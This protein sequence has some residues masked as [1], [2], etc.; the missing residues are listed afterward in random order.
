MANYKLLQEDGYAILQEDGSY[1]LLD[2]YAYYSSINKIR[3]RLKKL[4]VIKTET[5]RGRIKKTVTKYL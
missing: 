5:I 4:G 3:A 1:I 2:G